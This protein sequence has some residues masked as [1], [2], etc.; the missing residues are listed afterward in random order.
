[1]NIVAVIPSLNP[2][3]KLSKIVED[4][5]KIGFSRIYV[6]NDGSDLET[7][8]YFTSVATHAEC[9]VLQHPENKGKGRALKTAFEHFLADSNDCIGLVTLDG[10]GQHC[11]E[12]VLLVAKELEQNPDCLILGARDFS[13]QH[14]PLKSALGNRLTS[15][16]FCMFCGISITDTQTGLR[17]IPNSFVR[18]LLAVEGERYEFETNMLLQTKRAGVS[19]REIPIRTIYI[20]NNAASH[21]RP[22]LD[23]MRILGRI[24]KFTCSSLLSSLLDLSLF[25][26]L[27]TLLL[28][29]LSPAI[30][31]LLSTLSARVISSFFNFSLN[32][33]FVFSRTKNPAKKEL[34]RYLLLSASLL[35]LSYGGVY[36]LSEVALF[37]A[38]G[39]KIVV[40]FSLYFAS[41]Y[42]QQRWVFRH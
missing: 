20:D 23:S 33:S 13:L 32:R 35:F 40:D 21:Y 24:L 38:V 8:H 28:T 36:L 31:L 37:P 6:I 25:A 22:F 3:E 34:V 27:Y 16:I 41:F 18:N 5:I 1:M 10:D 14:V 7:L 12:D 4:L 39:A 29:P 15:F 26:L 17:G 9:I 2:D 30:R 11:A 42:I 19:V